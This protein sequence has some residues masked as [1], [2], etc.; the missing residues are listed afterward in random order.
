MSG[1][2]ADAFDAGLSRRTFL[3][4]CYTQAD[5]ACVLDILQKRPETAPFA[6]I[7]TPNAQHLVSLAYRN[8]AFLAGYR[9]AWLR[10]GDSRVVQILARILFKRELPLV[11]GSDLTARLLDEI[12]EPADPVCIIGGNNELAVALRDQYAL[13]NVYQH[14]PPMGVLNNPEAL[15]ACADF[16]ANHPARFVFLAIGAP[17]SELVAAMIRQGGQAKGIGLCIGSSLHFATGLVPR[18]PKWA[19]NAGLEWAHRLVIAP[20]AHFR[21]YVFHSAPILW[22]MLRARFGVP[23]PLRH[24][25]L[26]DS[27]ESEKVIAGPEDIRSRPV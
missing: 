11:R 10:L 3:G 14:Q 18:A 13:R 5:M 24:V 1:D 7:V 6:Y 2:A 12:I 4:L 19:R 16:V 22:L 15:R 8:E 23:E 9:N 26:P 25:E 21:K 27:M 20:K 17:Q